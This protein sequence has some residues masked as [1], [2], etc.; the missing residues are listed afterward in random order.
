MM[1]GR[2]GAIN[3][4]NNK[5]LV[6][7]LIGKRRVQEL[8]DKTT[9]EAATALRELVQK[10]Y[11]YAKTETKN[12][13]KP[14]DLRGHGDTLLPRV[15]NIEFLAT[16]KGKA[17]FLRVIRNALT[18]PETGSNILDETDLTI[19]DLYDVVINSGGF[20]QGD[21]TNLKADQTRSQ[22]DIDRDLKAQEYLDSL[23]TE[24]LLDDGLVL[25]D[26]QAILPR[27][28]QKAIERTEYAKRFGINDELLRAKIKEGLEQIGKHN[29][30]VLKLNPSKEQAGYIDPKR[31]EK[32]IWDMARILRNKYGY[33]I[34]NMNTRTWLQRLANI[35]VVA[36]LPLVTL[37][38]MPELFT[39]MLRGSTNPAAWTVDLMA[40][41]AWAGYKGMNG[42]SKLLLNKHLP[43]MRKASGEIGGLGIISDVQL[44]REMGIAEIQAMGDLVSTRYAN[45]N[46]A[47][48]GLRAGARGT[49]AGKIPKQVRSVFNMQVFMQAT[50]LTTLTEMQQLMA[51]RNFQRHMSRRVKFVN[52]NKGKKLKGRRLRLFQQFKQD[53]ADFGLNMDIDLDTS[54]GEADFNAGALRF[55]DQVITR[56]ND[57]TTAKAF[58]NPLTAPIFLFK[59]FITTFGNT[60]MTAVGNDMANKV[61]NIEQAKQIGRIVVA[62]T[63][64]YGAVMFAEIIR[65]AI[66]GDLDEDDMT[67][68]GGDFRS[69]VRRLDRTGLLSAP[70]AMAVNLA[71]PY[72]RGWWDTPEA[73]LVGELGGPILG[74]AAEI[75]A[76]ATDPKD[77]SFGRLVRQV[78]PLSK[79]VFPANYKKK[80]KSKTKKSNPSYSFSGSKSSGGYK[81]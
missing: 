75:M 12:L 69:F 76:Q 77:D 63:T 48:G 65:G 60:L 54:R 81:F 38:S 37:A 80:S 15:W 29:A 26:L 45:P 49:I 20:V 67:L 56:P 59:R 33:D 57:A 28:I 51:M 30:E 78:M 55:I 4:G 71:F 64:M 62:M 22:K 17:K 36:K 47:R 52:K 25:D 61:H 14:L 35:Q 7:V 16:R 19:D 41:L 73:R 66:K 24:G 18:N 79:K 1:T 74:D 32:S 23:E 21:W 10:V 72:K 58:K 2:T 6:D 27:F 42:I 44:L 50:L 39:P 53:M 43:A 68:T 34:T 11:N 9:R 31:F 3:K 8:P 46:F 13:E 5:T 70:G 40:G